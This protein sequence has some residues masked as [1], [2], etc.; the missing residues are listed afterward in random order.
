MRYPKWIAAQD[1]DERWA[2]TPQAKVLLPEVLRRLV[3]A[4]VPREHLQK[5]NFP[6]GAET[7]RPDYDGTTVTSQGTTF[8]PEGVT[9]WELGTEERPQR[10]ANEDYLNRIR[11]HD[12][13]IAAG[14]TDNIA[15]STYVAVTPRDWQKGSL[16][17]TECSEGT[18]YKRVLA[19]DSNQLEHWLYDAPAVSLWLAQQIHGKREGVTDV[20]QHWANTQAILRR[21]V[22][23]EALLVNRSDTAKAFEEWTS[24][25]NGGQLLMKAPSAVELVA[26]FCAWV[27]TLPQD[28]QDAVSSRSIIVDNRETWRSLATA[29]HPLILIASPRL[30]VEPEV[31]AEAIR[32]GHYA[33]RFADFRTPQS[34]APKTLAQMRRFDLQEALKKGG[35]PDGQARQLAEVAGGNFTILRRRLLNTS[36]DA[37]GW[38][39]DDSLM[40][41]L[42]CAAWEDE[43]IEDQKIVSDLADRKYSEVQSVLTKWRYAIDTP[44]RLIPD[45]RGA[46]VWEFLS[47][48]DAWEALHIYLTTPQL[49]RFQKLAV[50]VLSEDNPALD[51]PAED[52]IM[53][54]VKGKIP[55]FSGVLRHGIAEM[56]ALGATRGQ[57]GSVASEHRI[58]ERATFVVTSLLPPNCSWK[59]WAS[60]GQL[61]PLLVEAS[62]EAVLNAMERD[63]AY[64]DSQ[65]VELLRQEVPGGVFGAAY[66]SG[67]LWALET[68]AWSDAYFQRVTFILS[69]L[70]RR[71]P[72]GTWGNR[73]AASL[74]RIFFSWRAQT[75][76]SIGK[77]IAE[78]KNLSHKEPEPT[79]KLLLALL[80]QGHEVVFDN[81]KPIYRDWAAGW[82]GEVS[83]RDYAFFISEVTNIALDMAEMDVT[84]FPLL[85]DRAVHLPSAD[86]GKVISTLERS[87]APVASEH[88]SVLWGELREL[89]EKHTS[90]HDAWWALPPGEVARLAAL[91]DRVR[92]A[93]VVTTSKY[94]FDDDGH[95]DGDQTLTYEQKGE[96]RE[97]VRRVAIREVWDRG[98]IS[99]VIALAEQVRQP[100][101]VGWVL[102]D[103]LGDLSQPA[104]IPALLA[105][106]DKPS[107]AL[108]RAFA[109][110]RIMQKGRDWAEG[111]AGEEWSPAELAALAQAMPLDPRTWEWV[112]SHGPTTNQR[113]WE[114][115]VPWGFGRLTLPNVL[116]GVAELQAVGRAWSALDVWASRIHEK[117]EVPAA[118]LCDALDA[119]LASPTERPTGTMDAYHVQEAFGVLQKDPSVNFDR[120]ASLEYSFLPMLDRHSRLPMTLQRKLAREPRF[121][122]ECLSLLYK[123]KGEVDNPSSSKE[124]TEPDPETALRAQQVWRLLHDWVVIP[125][126]DESGNVS[127]AEL[128][129][130]LATARQLAKDADRLEVCDSTLGDLF[131][132]SRED[133]DGAKPLVAIREMIEELGSEHL[134]HGFHIGLRNLRGVVTKGHYEGGQQERDLASIFHR[135]SVHCS[136]WP[137][138]A[139]VL[140]GVAEN[141]EKDAQRE[142]ERAAARE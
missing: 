60:L 27:Q 99:A 28:Q 106:A 81:S 65:L 6:S 49:D 41:P 21:P 8:V 33:L 7:Q 131:A 108:A 57:E 24:A 120:V 3:F 31:F 124:D 64:E 11:I 20:G 14:K 89:V 22:S 10:K 70:A 114:E 84:R 13:L 48:L 26:V 141:Y 78:L 96:R 68:A 93:D 115:V 52:R 40:S 126:S 19:Y 105:S 39:Q 107:R 45:D 134:E 12:G 37:P 43:R 88:R 76:A 29:Q 83:E 123:R 9:F 97:E 32:G 125:G 90:F 130:W 73:P 100:W 4:T 58:A 109:S 63:V 47:P 140:R 92:P 116:R 95:M 103:T 74:T 46:K 62:P 102:A 138:T 1:L 44:V 30:S 86:L 104:I 117:L 42:L 35:F 82:T 80:P 34:L 135:Y 18:P 56:L 91:R 71:D 98:A 36:D 101:S 23:A 110:K 133:V 17:A 79:W 77:R 139:A 72:G 75:M 85:L 142:D 2:A 122:V 69:G 137:R 66:H 38:A 94:L 15:E 55:R 59:R 25:P 118:S 51:L 112:K 54:S 16:W 67:V 53:A 111:C 128:R 87:N 127:L 119:I 113:Y 121:F 132:R 136:K 50:E 61:L 5:I 129:G